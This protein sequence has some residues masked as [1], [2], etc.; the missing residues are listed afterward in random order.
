MKEKL[1]RNSKTKIPTLAVLWSFF[2]LS[3]LM[4][5]STMND[6]LNKMLTAGEPLPLQT[7]LNRFEPLWGV[8]DSFWSFILTEDIS[9]VI[10]YLNAWGGFT[11][12]F[13]FKQ[14]INQLT[15]KTEP[16][17]FT[18]REKFGRNLSLLYAFIILATIIIGMPRENWIIYAHQPSWHINLPNKQQVSAGSYMM[19]LL[20][21]YFH[22]LWKDKRGHEGSLK[23]YNNPKILTYMFLTMMLENLGSFDFFFDGLGYEEIMAHPQSF[24]SFDKVFHF[25]VSSAT[26][27]LLIMNMK[28][29]RLAVIL[30]ISATGMWELF[31][32]SL[33]PFEA[34]DSLKDLI[35]NSSAITLTALLINKFEWKNDKVAVEE[36]EDN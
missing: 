8:I 13:L 11:L 26:A 36:F 31:E 34:L 15:S 29:R 19:V 10:F 1:M 12:A 32:I 24:L 18:E 28:N 3:F 9:Y 16:P 22:G 35:I 6:I 2:T 30:A 20:F 21:I 23:F 14:I 4:N 25:F 33:N 17:T 5:L 7:V 27:V